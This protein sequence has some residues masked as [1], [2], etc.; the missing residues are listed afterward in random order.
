MV[1][2]I[3]GAL[4]EV[5]SGRRPPH[6]IGELLAARDRRQGGMTAPAGGLYLVAVDYPDCFGL[7]TPQAPWFPVP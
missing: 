2:N 4:I 5:G 6:W 3:A 1:R 7:P